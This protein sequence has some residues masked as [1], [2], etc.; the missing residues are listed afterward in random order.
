M[1]DWRK[2]NLLNIDNDDN[3]HWNSIPDHS[4]ILYRSYNMYMYIV[5]VVVDLIIVVPSLVARM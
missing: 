2:K 1:C 3:Y 4:D 5:V